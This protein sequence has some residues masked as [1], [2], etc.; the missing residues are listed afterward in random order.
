[1]RL[2]VTHSKEIESYCW[3]LGSCRGSKA[4]TICAGPR[5]SL[6]RFPYGPF[7]IPARIF[8]TLDALHSD[9]QV[10]CKSFAINA[11]AGMLTQ[12]IFT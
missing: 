8:A 7:R 3:I 12:K 1:M 11:A 9:T 5:D 6:K 10:K 4:S 2:M